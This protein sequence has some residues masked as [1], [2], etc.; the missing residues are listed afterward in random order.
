MKHVF[1]TSSKQGTRLIAAMLD[2]LGGGSVRQR[3]IEPHYQ[4]DENR[5]YFLARA[6]GKRARRRLRNLRNHS[7]LII[8]PY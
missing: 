3:I 8:R 2:L 4:S 1:K 7:Q 5:R 6:A